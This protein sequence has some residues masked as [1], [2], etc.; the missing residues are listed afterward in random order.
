MNHVQKGA[1][2]LPTMPRDDIAKKLKEYG[3]GAVVDGHRRG[4]N[5][6]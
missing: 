4:V 6:P 1:L 5:C 3:V 2:S